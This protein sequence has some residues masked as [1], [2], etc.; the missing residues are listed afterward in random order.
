MHEQGPESQKGMSQTQ[1]L[2]VFVKEKGQRPTIRW[3]VDF[4]KH[5]KH[6]PKASLSRRLRIYLP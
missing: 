2:K 6:A 5:F 3:N 4:P 1:T